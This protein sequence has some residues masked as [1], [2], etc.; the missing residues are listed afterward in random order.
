MV[1]HPRNTRPARP[2]RRLNTPR[3]ALVE[4]HA[5]GTPQQV[6]RQTVALTCEEWRVVDR[7]WTDQPVNRR[8][9]EI[10]LDSGQHTIVFHDQETHTWFSQNA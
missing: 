3:P 8:Y 4:T 6:N 5:D 1:A 10:V 9:F 7:W 2:T